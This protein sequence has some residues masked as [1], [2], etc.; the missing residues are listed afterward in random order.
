[1]EDLFGW[2][3]PDDPK[4]K[5]EFDAF[6]ARYPQAF[7]EFCKHAKRRIDEGH[8]RYSALGIVHEIRLHGVTV[9][10]SWAPFYARLFHKQFPAH[11]GF[12]EIRRAIAD[13]S[14]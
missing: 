12:F 7:R 1:M 4:L 13:K 2:S 10:N 14:N 6:H 8:R 9:S 11:N 5:R 3:P